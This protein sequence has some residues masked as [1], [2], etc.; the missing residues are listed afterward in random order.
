MIEESKTARPSSTSAGT[1]P[2]GL[3]LRNSGSLLPRFASTVSKAMSF[4]KSASF[5]FWAKGDSAT[6]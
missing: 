5:T 4:S 1:S 6:S 3:T 2:R